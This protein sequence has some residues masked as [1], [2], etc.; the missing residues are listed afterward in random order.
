MTNQK[1][2]PDHDHPGTPAAEAAG[3]KSAEGSPSA[4]EDAY[5]AMRAHLHLPLQTT[6]E[7]RDQ[8]RSLLWLCAEAVERQG[9]SGMVLREVGDKLAGAP[10]ISERVRAILE[11]Q[12]HTYRQESG[13]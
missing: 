13:R 10:P 11:I 12:R 9:R 4:L 5:A 1:N 7:V 2:M 6:D 3:W 8:L